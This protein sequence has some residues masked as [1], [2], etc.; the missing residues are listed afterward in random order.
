MSPSS[1]TPGQ[2]LGPGY[3]GVHV[4]EAMWLVGSNSGQSKIRMVVLLLV[5]VLYYSIKKL[6][7]ILGILQIIKVILA[8]QSILI[9]KS[10]INF[11]QKKMMSVYTKQYSV[12]FLAQWLLR[13]FKMLEDVDNGT[14][15]EPYRC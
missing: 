9:N 4:A 1:L 8:M 3:P 2:E 10:Y 7:A 15:G 5:L 14:Y 6:E 12:V 13:Q 11:T